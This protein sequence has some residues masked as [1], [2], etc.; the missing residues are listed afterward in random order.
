MLPYIVLDLMHVCDLGITQYLLG[1]IWLEMLYQI[2]GSMTRADEAL[3][4]LVVFIKHASKQLGYAKPPLNKLTIGM[5]KGKK[6][7]APRLGLKASDTRLMVPVTHF[8]LERIFPPTTEYQ[9][10]RF[11]CLHAMHL[12]YKALPRSK[13]DDGHPEF[14]SSKLGRL[15][16][17]H[18]TLYNELANHSSRYRLWDAYRVY[19]KHHLFVH[20]A[21]QDYHTHGNPRESWNYIDEDMIGIC[22]ESVSDSSQNC[23]YIHRS[24]IE[25]YRL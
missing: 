16:R 11:D 14:M 5:L 8:I 13:V 3:A 21:E 24:A 10:L 23:G 25:K 19:P 15:A 1:N 17:Q 4:Q 12:F 22:V 6:Q 2:G 7:K 20:L 18:L 9:R